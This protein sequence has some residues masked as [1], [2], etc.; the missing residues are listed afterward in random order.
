MV[1][2]VHLAQQ[3]MKN[4]KFDEKSHAHGDATQRMRKNTDKYEME[5]QKRKK[6][7][8]KT[9]KTNIK[10]MSKKQRNMSTKT[11]RHDK[12]RKNIRQK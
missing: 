8:P 11:E 2:H 3:V 12:K 1:L 10:I 6:H 7:V 9:N 5:H 4:A